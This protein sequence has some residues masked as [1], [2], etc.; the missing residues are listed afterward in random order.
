MNRTPKRLC[1]MLIAA[2]LLCLPALAQTE[3]DTTAQLSDG[4]SRVA[5]EGSFTVS[6][7][8]RPHHQEAG[9]RQVRHQADLQQAHRR[10]DV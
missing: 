2:C 9:E 4:C 1:T 8:G 10:A 5:V 6:A 7:P 3:F